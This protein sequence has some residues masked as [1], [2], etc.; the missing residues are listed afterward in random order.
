M[1]LHML[2]RVLWISRQFKLSRVVLS[3]LHMPRSFN[4]CPRQPPTSQLRRNAH[5]PAHCP[6]CSMTPPPARSVQ[7]PC[8]PNASRSDI[9]KVHKHGI[10]A[11]QLR[12]DTWGLELLSISFFESYMKWPKG[13]AVC[14]SP[15]S[16]AHLCSSTA[17]NI[18]KHPAHTCFH[19]QLLVFWILAL[20]LNSVLWKIWCPLHHCP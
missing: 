14:K 7:G 9:A 15:H 3:F 11:T 12:W 20:F 1:Q 6:P 10:V 5:I 4:P 19:L 17:K 8:W 18:S 2:K 13:A 16:P